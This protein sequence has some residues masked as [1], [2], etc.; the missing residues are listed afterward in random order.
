MASFTS[1]FVHDLKKLIPQNKYMIRGNKYRFSVLSPRLIRIEYDEEGNFEDRAT[2]LVINRTFP[3]FNFSV[4]SDDYSVNIITEYF[5]LVYIKEKPISGNNIKINLRGTEKYWKPG[6]NDVR[7]FGGLNYSLD[8][9][10]KLKLDKGLY[11]LDGF[12]VIDDSKNYVIDNNLFVSRN[13]TVD[14]YLFFYKKDLG[15]CL[16]DYFNLTGYPSMIPRYSLGTWWYKNDDYS[17]KDIDLILKKFDDYELPV[18]VFMLGDK[19]HNNQN[20]YYFDDSKFDIANIH[21][22][23]NSYN[24]K[25]GVTINPRLMLNSTDPI[26]NEFAKYRDIDKNNQISLFPLD[27]N[28]IALYIQLI[29]NRLYQSGINIFSIDYDNL[30]DINGLFMLNHYHYVFSNMNLRGVILS[31]N[32]MIAP[33]RYPIIYSGRT[34]VSWNTLA[35]LVTYNNSAANVGVTWHAHAIGGY[36]GGKEDAELYIR[37]I[38]FGVFNP[39]FILASDAGKYYKREPWR[40]NQLYLSV[41]KDF[42][43]FRNKLIPYIY[44]EGFKY[45]KL[46]IPLVQPLYYKYPDIYDEPDY[47]NQFFFGSNIM[48]SP[49]IKRR[50]SEMNRVVQKIFIPKGVWYDYNTGKKFIGNKYYVSFYKLEDYPIFIKEGTIIPMSLDENTDNPK[51]ME[52]Q[53]FPAENGL[54]GSYQLY[55]D[56]GIS[57]D[58]RNNN[59]ITNMTLDKIDIGYRFMIK[60]KSG[61]MNIPSRNYFLK[62]RNMKKPDKVT[63]KFNNNILEPLEV[64]NEK[65][66]L[67]ISLE[68]VSVYGNLEVVIEGS[69]IEIETVSVINEEIQYIL[70]DLSINTVIKEKIDSI[71]FSDLS[72]KK[73]RIALRKLKKDKLEPKFITMFINLLE[74][75]E[76]K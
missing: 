10:E 45:H 6:H 35:N 29:V 39:I 62:F 4:K 28:S 14:L 2:S 31:R 69:N 9:V 1:Y 48:I 23:F 58:N 33:H 68:N 54:Y 42:L 44:T 59:L 61:S 76:I 53:I 56:D 13:K 52:I 65:N 37:Y 63:V 7:N 57:L 70:D 36:Y 64:K 75:M 32:A 74:F 67:I 20:N 51:N 55:E 38:Q 26:Y 50:N 47:V 12:S 34:R 60:T 18:S 72:I 19:W 49:I 73:K 5:E 25:F 24:Q 11:S 3:N 8:E 22:Y 27:N 71:I 15:L 40:W 30:K 41:I 43:Q 46:G 21:N 16:Q 17:T 66:D